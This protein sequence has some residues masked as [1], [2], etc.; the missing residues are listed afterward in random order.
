MENSFYVY[1]AIC[2]AQPLSIVV[3]KENKNGNLLAILNPNTNPEEDRQ[4]GKIDLDKCYL[5]LESIFDNDCQIMSHGTTFDDIKKPN[6]QT[7]EE[8]ADI[9]AKYILTL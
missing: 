2:T 5:V 7:N 3:L 8:M 9:I 1:W 6:E 4:E